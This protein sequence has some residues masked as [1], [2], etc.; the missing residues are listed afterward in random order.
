MHSQ[1]LTEGFFFFLAASRDGLA[2]NPNYPRPAE[3]RKTAPSTYNTQSNPRT[4]SMLAVA[5]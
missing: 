5:I 2:A 4:H 3:S 1:L